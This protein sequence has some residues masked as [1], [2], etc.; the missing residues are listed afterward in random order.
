MW[1]KSGWIVEIRPTN[2]VH[3]V[4]AGRQPR[5]PRA[6]PY[7]AAVSPPSARDSHDAETPGG[8]VGRWVL[9]RSART[10]PD[11]D[12]LRPVGT[13]EEDRHRLGLVE[14]AHHALELAR[15]RDLGIGD[16]QHHITL[17]QPS[18]RRR[19]F[20]RFDFHASLHLELALDG[21]AQVGDGQ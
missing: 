1:R 19:A 3:S 10:R 15:V 2:P 11:H 18:A 20:G 8:L 12:V 5:G 16:R 9:P 13:A 6:N 21:L 7:A 14:L 4:S 17:A